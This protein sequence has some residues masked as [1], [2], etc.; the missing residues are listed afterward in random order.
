MSG[1]CTPATS[2]TN[3]PER[4][5]TPIA[6][7]KTYFRLGNNCSVGSFQ[8]EAGAFGSSTFLL[9]VIGKRLPTVSC[10]DESSGAGTVAG[11]HSKL[12]GALR[13]EA[14]RHPMLI[15]SF[16]STTEYK[17]LRAHGFQG[18]TLDDSDIVSRFREA[19]MCR[20]VP[21]QLKEYLAPMDVSRL[22]TIVSFDPN[23][24]WL[25]SSLYAFAQM[26]ATQR[27]VLNN[28][29]EFSNMD[30]PLPRT[31]AIESALPRPD[32]AA[33]ISGLAFRDPDIKGDRTSI[34]VF[35]VESEHSTID[36]MGQL[37]CVAK[38]TL[39]LYRLMGMADEKL[40]MFAAGVEKTGITFYCFDAVREGPWY[41]YRGKRIGNF[42]L[43]RLDDLVSFG[44]GMEFIAR[45]CYAKREELLS[46]TIPTVIKAAAD[47]YDT[48]DED[49]FD[50]EKFW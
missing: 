18:E 2:G 48:D 43:T 38:P 1:G 32:W 17:V 36:P 27:D 50:E 45:D 40:H 39:D 30:L 6:K 42:A 49:T 47:V 13:L 23:E 31:M 21:E 34:P 16:L 20:S 4:P 29:V 8:T 26:I 37:G 19:C 46:K 28:W 5:C 3:S 24:E 15:S 7:R 41:G 44:M 33:C 9:F 35:A 11:L 14:P 10:F 12:F 22:E 25:P